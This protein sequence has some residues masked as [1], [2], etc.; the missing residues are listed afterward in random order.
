MSLPASTDPT[1]YST[2]AHLAACAILPHA[3]DAASC[4]TAPHPSLPAP[5][6][7]PG[8][9]KPMKNLKLKKPTGTTVVLVLLSLL[10][11]TVYGAI[12]VGLASQIGK[13]PGVVHGIT[14][15]D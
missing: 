11:I 10:C 12:A 15:D 6:R 9:S 1:R 8:V 7:R 13:A 4:Q 5:G 3:L 2:E 14:A